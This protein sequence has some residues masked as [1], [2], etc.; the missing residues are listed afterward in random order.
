MSQA[1]T[2]VRHAARGAETEPHTE[3]PGATRIFA[4]VVGT[5]AALAGI[6]H[7]VGEILQ[8]SVPPESIVI[9]S[10]PAS[11]AFEILGGEPAMTVV[12]NLVATGILAI[13]V[14]VILGVWAVGFADRRRGGLVLILLSLLL[15][16]VGG[17]FGPPLI[18][19]IAGIAA[20]GIGAV[21]RRRPGTLG[22]ALGTAWAWI[23]GAAV[24]GYLGLVPGIP[25]LATF[26]GVESAALVAALGLFA[27]AAL[28][29][30]LAAARARDRMVLPRESFSREAGWP[31]PASPGPTYGP[32]GGERHDGG[33]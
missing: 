10:W 28:F 25:L 15:F 14:S 8:G 30:A 31:V 17:G 18:G 3:G 29:L 12:P 32:G 4:S 21:P 19:V 27:F 6:E 13:A 22:R 9:E 33:G 16:L 11:E 1:T 26:G 5:L 24:L 23:L 7:G 20:T 2:T